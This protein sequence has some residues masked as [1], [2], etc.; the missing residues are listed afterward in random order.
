MKETVQAEPAMELPDV[1]A[2]DKDTLKSATSDLRHMIQSSPE[3]EKKAEEFIKTFRDSRIPLETFW[4]YYECA[5]MEIKTKF[6][7]LNR[8]LSLHYDGNPIESIKARMKSI[9]S[10]A[11]KVI[12]KN[13][14]WTLEAVEENINDIAGIRVVC[15]FEEDIYRLA[16]SF[17]R[18]DDITLIE[19]KDYIKNPKPS[20]YRSLHLIVSVP[21]FL[22]NEKKDVKV[23]VQFRTI[24]M[25]FWASLEHKLRYKKDLNPNICEDLA[26][27]LLECAEQSAALDRRMQNIRDCIQ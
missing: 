14:P 8:Q 27:Q 7:V 20:G 6:N 23:E 22:E 15:S 4:M 21:I 26:G 24:A 12:R 9:D 2:F 5:I 17:L 3:N 11:L 16:D 10:L 1:P 19:M 25:D 18:Q 13:I